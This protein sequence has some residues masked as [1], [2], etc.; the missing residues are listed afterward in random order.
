MRHIVHALIMV[1]AICTADPLSADALPFFPYSP[2]GLEASIQQDSHRF[3]AIDIQDP[4]PR[5]L[6]LDR[7]VLMEPQQESEVSASPPPATTTVFWTKRHRKK[8]IAVFVFVMHCLGFFT[9]IRAMMETRTSQGAVAWVISLNTF[10]YFAVPAYWVFGQS[11]FSD[12]EVLRRKNILASSDTGRETARILEE[13]GM[14]VTP[15]TEH[16]TTTGRTAGE[17]GK[18][19][20]HAIQRCRPADRRRSH[21]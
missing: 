5:L 17:S 15:E 20:L 10:P 9:S 8:L 2:D 4:A 1:S 12:Y 18:T 11:K 14:F 3:S 13:G 19:A 16:D 6:A 7:R 21:V